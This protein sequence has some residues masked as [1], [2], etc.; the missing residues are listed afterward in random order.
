MNEA[1]ERINQ[2]G[3][4]EAESQFRDCC[5]STKWAS[6][7]ASARPFATSDELINTA[8][9]IWNEMEPADRLEAFKAHPMIGETKAAPAQQARSA[10]WSAGEQAG[11]SSA[12][13]LL[14]NELGAANRAYYEKFGFI[15]IVCATGKTAAEMLEL[16][17]ERLVNNRE[18]EIMI[19][20]GEQEKI[21]EIRLMKL[22]GGPF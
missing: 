1:L 14:K 17:R 19:A 8:T 18:T 10:K 6:L 11:V 4:A 15:F 13:E 3:K 5:G 21:T 16:C 12:D 9:A 22:C 20:A 2:A 7:M